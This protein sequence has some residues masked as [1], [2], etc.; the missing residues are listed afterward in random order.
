MGGQILVALNGDD[1]LEQINPY[2]EKVAQPGMRVVYLIRYSVSGGLKTV[3]NWWTSEDFLEEPSLAQRKILERD[4]LVD[5][6]VRLTQL[7]VFLAQEALRKKGVE[8]V[9]D[10]YTGRLKKVVERYMRR[11]DVKFILSRARGVLRNRGLLQRALS[12]F[13]LFKRPTLS[14]MLVVHPGTPV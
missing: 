12:L 5:D 2:I 1:R 14:P 13:G 6:Q 11:G 7:K 3:P 8:I 9:A 10:V 4:S